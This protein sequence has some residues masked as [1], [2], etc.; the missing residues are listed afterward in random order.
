MIRQYVFKVQFKCFIIYL[1]P[2]FFLLFFFWK[3]KFGRSYS[4]FVQSSQS[5]AVSGS[6]D[7]SKPP[8]PNAYSLRVRVRAR[9][10]V[11]VCA[12]VCIYIYRESGIKRPF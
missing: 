1:F 4:T 7:Q 8:N 6:I 3:T 2:L 11:C 9:V 12:C 10:C 5:G